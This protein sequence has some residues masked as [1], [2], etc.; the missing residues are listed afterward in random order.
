MLC[1]IEF[2]LKDMMEKAGLMEYLDLIMSNED[3]K[4]SKPD[5][6]IYISATQKLELEP[7]ECLILEDNKNG[8]AAAKR[9][10]GNLLQ[11]DTVYDVTYINIKTRIEQIENGVNIDGTYYDSSLRK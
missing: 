10:G 7:K 9:S 1:I 11:I 4:K 3:V 6:E 2:V 8:I 5:P